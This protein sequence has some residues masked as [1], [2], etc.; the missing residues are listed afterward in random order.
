[1][2]VKGILTAKTNKA[3]CI[4]HQYWFPLR[5]LSKRTRYL[6][7]ILMVG[8]NITLEILP[9]FIGYQKNGKN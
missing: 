4:E 6:T 5:A 1:M 9:W 7:K 3:V 8:D 2:K